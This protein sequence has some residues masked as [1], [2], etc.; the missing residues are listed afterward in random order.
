MSSFKKELHQ[1]LRYARHFGIARPANFDEEHCFKDLLHQTADESRLDFSLSADW[2]TGPT[3]REQFVVAK[4]SLAFLSECVAIPELPD[5]VGLRPHLQSLL[6]LPLEHFGF[7]KDFEYVVP[8]NLSD[9]TANL[10]NFGTDQTTDVTLEL[11]DLAARIPQA[12]L[13]ER[14]D[15]TIE[16]V[17]LIKTLRDFSPHDDNPVEVLQFRVRDSMGILP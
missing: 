8:Q 3:L 15:V 6:E 5:L 16:S 17:K 4:E 9:A 7:D 1:L 12:T 10:H 11:E 14:L 2:Q 13:R